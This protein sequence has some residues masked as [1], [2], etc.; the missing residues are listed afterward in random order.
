MELSKKEILEAS[1]INVGEK[2]DTPKFKRD[3]FEDIW[4]ILNKT[5]LNVS[6]TGLRRV[7]KTTLIKQILNEWKDKAFYF[8]F[9]EPRY[10]NY[11]SLKRVI[12]VFIDEGD[13]EKPLIVLDEVGKIKEWG[14]L[15]KKYYDRGKAR[16]IVSG[17]SSLSISKGRESLA[18]R[19][20]ETVLPPLQYNEYLRFMH[21][22]TP[23][24]KFSD[25]F[26][27][28]V[29]NHIEEFFF[30]GSF[31]E[32]VKMDEDLAINYVKN[33][34]ISKIIFEDIPDVFRI[35]YRNKLY[36]IFKYMTEY[37]GNLIY[38]NNLADVLGINKTTV[39]EYI[40]YLEQA[41]L[42]YKIFTEG[43][44]AKRLRKTKK[45]YVAT[46]VLYRS[47]ASTFNEGIIAEVSVFDK[48]LSVEGK[49]PVFYRDNQKREIDF[50]FKDVPIEV[51]Y[52]NTIT[53]NDLRWLLH[54]LEKR[55]R[56]LGIIITKD[57]LDEKILNNKRVLFIPLYM[58]LAVEKL[59]NFP[60]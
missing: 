59:Q 1:P 48:L 28:R 40:L 55:N 27:R 36:E 20:F 8:S 39:S 51:K 17:S 19:I 52:K 50:I 25:I 37:S 4:K 58:F 18:G 43:S 26:K 22:E 54:Y 29:R 47:F 31:P 16:F 15:I 46:P 11:E 32:I 41:F 7:G 2:E 9:D 34:V 23:I 53:R 44:L 56:D 14:G 6:I 35:E 30:H 13:G 38:E 21:G 12:E 45:A 42:S 57:Y 60:I 3:W 10:Q 49:K 33:S 5:E 24:Y